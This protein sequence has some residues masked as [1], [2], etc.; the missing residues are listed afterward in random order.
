[1]KND[2]KF[3]NSW[4]SLSKVNAPS[5]PLPNTNN[6]IGYTKLIAIVSPQI[7]QDQLWKLFDVVPG[8]DYC[9]LR[10]EGHPKPNRGVASIVYNSSQWAAYA[11]EKL[12]GFEYPPGHRIIV[13]PDSEGIQNLEGRPS[14][15]ERTKHS[16]IIQIAE[17]I[18]QATN[19]IQ[20]AGLSPG[21][22]FDYLC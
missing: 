14:S 17:T 21:K 3:S 22:K 13:K 20:A 16:D 11:K 8:L 2:D 10:L 19:L 15:S 12:H 7:N 6:S 18:A 5:L 4:S 1:M 9:H